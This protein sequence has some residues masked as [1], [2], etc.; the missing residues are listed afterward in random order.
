MHSIKIVA[1]ATAVM[2]T[3]ILP[4]GAQ[5]YSSLSGPL[6]DQLRGHIVWRESSAPA[7][8]GKDLLTAEMSTL[9]QGQQRTTH[10]VG[11]WGDGLL[12]VVGFCEA[13]CGDLDLVITD[14]ATGAEIAS[15]V[16]TDS[17]PVITFRPEAARSYNVVARMYNCSTSDGCYFVTA[18]FFRLD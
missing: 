6:L 7:N 2:C 15:D 9:R 1:I 14:A 11:D 12:T 4:A 10:L 5:Q 8:E 16:R 13:A 3:S 18:S 17:R